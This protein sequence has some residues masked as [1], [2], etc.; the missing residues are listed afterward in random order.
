MPDTDPAPA[1]QR[2]GVLKGV[3]WLL[4]FRVFDRAAG[5]FSFLILARLL[6]PEHFGVV[7]LGSAVV[8]FIE[9][10]ASLG[11]D[12]I[13]VQT[14]TLTRDHYDTAW[15]IQLIIALTCSSLI[16]LAAWPAAMF[17]REPRLFIVLCL[18]A[19]ALAVEGL[20]NIRMV[21]FRREM[22]FDREFQ[23]MATRRTVT[24]LVTICAAL[25]LR[26]EWALALGT[27]C[28]RLVGTTMSYIM[29]PH[30]PRLTLALR[31]EFVNK[32]SWLLLG[33]VVMFARQRSADFVLGRLNGAASVGAYTLANDLATMATQELVGPI[34]RVSLSDLSQQ[35]SEKDVVSR[36]D[37]V[38]GL[39]AIVLAPVGLGLSACA[40]A[41]VPV[42]FGNAWV[43][44]GGLLQILALAALVAS[45]ASNLG[46]PIISLGHYRANAMIHAVGALVQVPLLIA[47][48]Y[49]YG[50]TGAAA[51]VLVANIV[52]VSTA[53]F[54]A[55]GAIGYGPLDFLRCVWRPL[56]VAALMYAAISAVDAWA[57]TSGYLQHPAIRLA[58][59][60][61]TGTV[62]YPP[63]L[64]ALWALCGFPEGGERRML[65]LLGKLAARF[66]RKAASA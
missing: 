51:A 11:L 33:N 17:F 44:A 42:L 4:A 19:T 61:A 12:T 7:A 65:T 55:K 32:S 39:I 48:A 14:K 46:V 15:T 56:L 28:A 2:G 9:I 6:L 34:N 24:V 62:L 10:L 23:F 63:T 3:A 18:L 16:A 59:L 31:Q 26:N 57:P 50:P 66:S 64:Y 58:L 53:L 1:V 13:L 22:R 25:W 30:W 36:F 27:L 35:E 47:C 29:R 21:D 5:V 54:I 49:L 41:V 43:A 20:Q 52:T 37:A 38:T 40:H 8:A 45:L 60:V